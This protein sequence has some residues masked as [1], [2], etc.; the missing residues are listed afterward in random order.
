MSRPVQVVSIVLVA[1]GAISIPVYRLNREPLSK[2]EKLSADIQALKT[3]LERY[4]QIHGSYPKSVK[5]Q[6][7]PWG[8]DYVYVYPGRIRGEKYDLFSAGPDHK[9][10]T[11]DDDWGGH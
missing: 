8:T 4:R 6:K 7:D 10:D 1:L 5:S 11:A 3:E 9:P 2:H